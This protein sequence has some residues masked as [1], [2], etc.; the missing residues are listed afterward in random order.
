MI[1]WLAS[2]PK[3]G[4][5]WVRILINQLL[6]FDKN[7]PN[8]LDDINNI[9]IY[10]KTKQFASLSDNLENRENIVKNWINSQKIICSQNK[11]KILKTHNVLGSFGKD[12]FTNQDL[13]MGVIH[14]VR[15]PRNIATSILNHYSLQTQDDAK[16]F[17]FEKNNWIGG[18]LKDGIH[19]DTFISS[20]NIHF[21]SW[22]SFKKNYILIKY[23]DLIKDCKKELIKISQYLNQFINHYVLETDFDLILKRSSF[24]K[25]QDLE[26]KGKFKEA[27]INKS[28]GNKVNFF[29]LGPK[30][31]WK[32]KLEPEISKKIENEFR[33]EMIELGYL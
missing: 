30:N 23:E 22:R 21:K 3:S 16:K 33:Q 29:N 31:D 25:L 7:N 10:P 6:N 2:Y 17:L 28:T 15:D 4:N 12:I 13:T 9:E 18:K 19:L 1:I 27:V 26:N 32:K 11:V 5:T 14:I 20:W 8:V 24:E